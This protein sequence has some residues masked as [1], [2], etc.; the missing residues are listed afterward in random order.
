LP[1]LSYY[2]SMSLSNS[3]SK[4]G[5]NLKWIDRRNE[6][7]PAKEIA[8]RDVDLLSALPPSQRAMPELPPFSP[9]S[10]VTL[11]LVQPQH[12][13]VL[14]LDTLV[15][16]KSIRGVKLPGSNTVSPVI[17]GMTI[18]DAPASSGDFTSVMLAQ[19]DA[20]AGD[21]TFHVVAPWTA[22]GRPGL[23]LGGMNAATG[24]YTAPRDGRRCIEVQVT[25]AAGVNG[26]TRTI[27]VMCLEAGNVTATPYVV[28]SAIDQPSSNADVPL[29]QSLYV[30]VQLHAGDK[31]WVECSNNSNVPI[32]LMAGSGT[33][34]SAASM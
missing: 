11:G 29:M 13:S 32:D 26:G 14:A 10:R 12:S 23:S 22:S 24:V 28:D 2:R 8:Q 18:E 19:N 27:R 30:Q 4:R 31:V 25:W 5:F 7:P 9:Y 21:G 16:T 1:P 6:D 15:V 33:A 17:E 34:F 20:V 3:W